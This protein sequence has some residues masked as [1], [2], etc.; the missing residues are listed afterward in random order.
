ML[1]NLILF[2]GVCNFCNFWVN[3]IIVRDRKARFNFTPLQSVNAQQFLKSKSIDSTKIDSIVLIVN[4]EIF[5]KSSAVIQIAR[6]LDGFWKLFYIFIIIPPFLRN[7]I[8]DFVASKRY[9]WFGRRDTCRIPNDS[10]K[11]RFIF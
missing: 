5:L 6:K 9:K 7:R 10:E 1:S 8:Y 11:E 4:D 3:F 2:D